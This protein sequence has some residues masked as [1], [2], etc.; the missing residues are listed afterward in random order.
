MVCE[1]VGPMPAATAQGPPHVTFRALVASPFPRKARE[2]GEAAQPLR[3]MTPLNPFEDGR[4][5][6]A[7]ANAHGHQCI[8]PAGAVQ[9]GNR[10]GGD[11]GARG[12][13]GVAERDA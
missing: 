2:K 1:V 7:A 11:D 3:G 5:A 4:N 9:L 12:T 8:A 13:H 10:L 6:L